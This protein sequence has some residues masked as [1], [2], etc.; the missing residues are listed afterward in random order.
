MSSAQRGQFVWHELITTDTAGASDFYPRIAG[1]KTQAWDNDN[2]YTMWV[3]EEGP[4]GGIMSLPKEATAS[5]WMP[6]ISTD[7]VAA[8]VAA[9]RELGATVC[10][11]TTQLPNG[12]SFAMLQ[13]PQGAVFAIHSDGSNAP[14]P[15]SSPERRDFSW[16]ELSTGDLDS[17]LE[18]YSALFGWDAAEKHDMG[19]LGFYQLFARNGTNIGGMYVGH[20]GMSP[21]WLSYVRVTSVDDAAEAAKAA[22]GRIINGPMEVPGGDWIAQIIDP[23]GAAFAVHQVKSARQQ[24]ARAAAK[25]KASKASK[26]KRVAEKPAQSAVAAQPAAKSESGSA[27]PARKTASSKSAAKSAKGKR[28]AR[29]APARAKA[30]A[31]AKA[32]RRRASAR[33]AGA[34]KSKRSAKR[35]SVKRSSS[36][37]RR[38]AARKKAA[39]RTSR[40]MVRTKRRR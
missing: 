31:K 3:G 2:S 32:S 5:H 30:A 19:E 23:Q 6:Y 38:P 7:D 13:D 27:R 28:K 37:R 17:A 34:A 12:G 29:R 40:R 16:H 39:R 1:W 4:L 9:A 11:E 8:T 26:A 25:S 24:P 15:G 18:F 21:H 35:A 10:K 33:A 20:P 22:G 14:S 36:A